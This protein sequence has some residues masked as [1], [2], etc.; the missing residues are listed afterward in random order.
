[1]DVRGVEQNLFAFQPGTLGQAGADGVGNRRREA[2]Q[3]GGD[4]DGQVTFAV[5]QRQCLGI[6][7]G[8]DLFKRSIP[9]AVAGHVQG[10][11]G[12]DLDLGQADLPIGVLGAGQGGQGDCEQDCREK[13]ESGLERDSWVELGGLHEAAEAM[14]V[15]SWI[16]AGLEACPPASQDFWPAGGLGNWALYLAHFSKTAAR[17]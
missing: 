17:F 14:P 5:F 9:A 12:R 13:A 16:C 10:L 11:L 15:P 7:V 8:G 1:M 2:D 3:V 6:E 4:Q